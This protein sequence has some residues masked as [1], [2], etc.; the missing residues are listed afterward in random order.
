MPKVYI[1]SLHQCRRELAKIYESCKA[2]KLDDNKA[3]TLTFILRAIMEAN[4]KYD[5]ENRIVELEKTIGVNN[6]FNE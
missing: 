3:K 5:L 2:E 1:E 4:W 6:E